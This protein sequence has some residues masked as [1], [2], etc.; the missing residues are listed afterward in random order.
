M[1]N[2]M[3]AGT[4]EGDEEEL[5]DQLEAVKTDEFQ[6]L[7]PLEDEEK[8]EILSE[9][10][11]RLKASTSFMNTL[12]PSMIANYKKYSSIADPI[13]NELGEE[14]TARSNLFVPYPFALVE[15]ELPRLA[16]RLPRT[17]AFPRRGEVDQKKVDAIQDLIYYSLDRMNFIETQSLWLRQYGIY[18]WSP[19]FYFWKNETRKI[20]KRKMV[21]LPTGETA[22]KLVREDEV[23]WDDFFATVLD[24]FDCFLQPGVEKF[25]ENSEWFFFREW[26]SKKEIMKMVEA[27]SLYPA[28]S[29]YLKDT[30]KPRFTPTQEGDG[31]SQRDALKGIQDKISPY[32]YGKFELM[33]CLE[34]DR[35]VQILD[36]TVLARAGDNPH[37]LQIKP[38]LNC[39]L[40]PLVNEPIGVG[41]IESMGGLPEKLNALSNARMDN[42]AMLVNKPV[43]ANRFAQT[44]FKNLRMESGNVILTDDVNNSVKFLDVPDVNV[45]SEREIR[46][47][48]ED[49]QFATAINSY[50]AGSDTQPMASD[51]ATGVSSMIRE[52]NARFAL[53]L[54][55]FE[56]GSLRKLVNVMHIYHMTYM[57]EK[58]RIHILGPK[59]YVI[60]DLK[61]EDIMTECDF[62][63]EP[64]SSV[65]LDQISRREALTNLLDRV[66]KAGTVIDIGKYF[67]EVLEAHDIRN[68]DDLMV[69]KDVPSTPYD[70]MRMAD[71][72]N[73]ALS[74]GESVAVVGDPVLHQQIHNKPIQD[75]SFLKWDENA[76]LMLVDHI[77]SHVQKQ[78]QAA[79]MAGGQ[80]GQG[81][82]GAVGG[83]LPGMGVPQN[84]VGGGG[85]AAM[86]ANPGGQS[87]GILGNPSAPPNG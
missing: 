87:G 12:Y 38:I 33:W 47:T 24:V 18:G 20:F 42:I 32:A 30:N 23:I 8:A 83:G 58:K 62:I 45:S 16:G 48:K 10:L 51:T 26:Y 74:M 76:K 27:G 79:M 56:S 64:G 73:I 86:P 43:L 84:M 85:G 40:T 37:P 41:T 11:S 50:F 21:P 71:A 13:K 52:G 80:N 34:D 4:Y 9:M 53:K 17:R 69:V 49:L 6:I 36:R 72:E 44:D 19:L 67:K 63:I 29:D 5:E 1:E 31:R 59:G 68:I 3:A 61:A 66:M 54:S 46:T 39:N 81:I 2:L 22:A 57:P 35:V 15:S 14:I 28:V 60:K 82:S 7:Y 70:D 25:E 78:Q 65:P 77:K 75:Q 55:A